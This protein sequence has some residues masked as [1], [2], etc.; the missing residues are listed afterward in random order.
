MDEID[1]LHADKHESFLKF[2]SIA[3]SKTEGPAT[4]VLVS[5]VLRFWV[6]T[7]PVCILLLFLSKSTT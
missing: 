1:C 2:M 6:F 3:E 7:G 4:C 5:F